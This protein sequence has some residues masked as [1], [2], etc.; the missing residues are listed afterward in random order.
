MDY[1]LHSEMYDKDSFLQKMDD[2]MEGQGLY[3][4]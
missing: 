2:Y 1:F 4:F 3:F